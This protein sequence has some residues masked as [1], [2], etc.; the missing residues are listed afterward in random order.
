[1]STHILCLAGDAAVRA[2]LPR[3]PNAQA[4]VYRVLRHIPT[5]SVTDD[6]A[7]RPI[8]PEPERI[9]TIV[10]F[11]FT[12]AAVQAQAQAGAP[13]RAFTAAVEEAGERLYAFDAFS[14]VPIAPAKGAAEGGFR[15]WMLL[16]RAAAS[17][18]AFRDAWFGR[19]ADL[20]KQLP[21][22]D[23]YVQNLVT[24][25]LGADGQPAEYE[26]L[27]VDGIAELCFADESAMLEA[28]AADARL[29]LR[30]DGRALLAGIV[31]LLVQGS[32][33]S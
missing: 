14:N 31:T 15:R 10:E 25:R 26:S 28:Y 32:R 12:D 17:P 8:V 23:G 30:D 3:L 5:D 9:H 22:V 1:M 27:R 16:R 21:R 20:V 19:H 11:S 18:A 2:A 13:W 24:A 6:L 33:A 4:H 7:R 29:P